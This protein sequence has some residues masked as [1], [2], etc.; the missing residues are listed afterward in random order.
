MV[1][2]VSITLDRPISSARILNADDTADQQALAAAL[3]QANALIEN[4]KEKI[5]VEKQRLAQS[6][7]AVNDAAIQLQQFRETAAV[8]NQKQL[9]VLA[10]QIAKKIICSE[11]EEG[12]YDIKAIIE[13]TLQAAPTRENSTIRLNPADSET[14][15]QI[16]KSN[17]AEFLENVRVESDWSISPGQCVLETPKGV[18]EY[19]MD[20]QLD[21]IAEAF[22]GSK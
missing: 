3:E 22:G 20:D 4:E 11:I 5:E 18:V 1:Q 6:L 10:V 9:G 19:F 8:D 21:R 17:G 15:D 13:K 7:K 14:I 2:T 12:K 16:L